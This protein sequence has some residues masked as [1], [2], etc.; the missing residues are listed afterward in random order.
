M[1]IKTYGY[2]DNVVYQIDSI[3][4]S[5]E[6][7]RETLYLGDY[8]PTSI[9]EWANQIAASVENKVYTIPRWLI[10][11]LAKIGDIA[12]YLKIS[13]PMNSFRFKNMTTN[14]ILPLN[15]TKEIAPFTKVSRTEGNLNTIEWMKKHYLPNKS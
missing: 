13:F 7:N 11:L 4:N 15:R 9:K 12:K 6:C 2:I 10:I 3:I 14:N 1:S 8:E 5:E